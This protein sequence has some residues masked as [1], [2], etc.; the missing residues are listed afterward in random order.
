[1]K[2]SNPNEPSQG[3]EQ[4]Q[5]QGNEQTQAQENEQTQVHEVREYE[6][7]EEI[8]YVDFNEVNVHDLE[9]NDDGVQNE[10]IDVGDEKGDDEKECEKNDDQDQF[11]RKKR[12]R[13][14]KAYAD[15]TEVTAKD[16]SIKLQCIHCKAFL[17]KSASSTTTHLWNH[18][19]RCTQKKLHTKNQKTLQFQNAKSK[20]ETPLLSDGKYDHM[21]QREAIAHWILIHEQPLNVVENYGF[22]FMFKANLP[23]FEK[24]SRAMARND[25]ITVYEI[26]KKKL[27]SMLRTINKISLTTDIWK[28]KVQKISYMCVT[29]HFVDSNWQLQK[30]VLSFMPL[31]PPHTGVDIIYG[32][33]KSTKDWGIEHK[34]FTISVDNASNN[35]VAI[36]IAKQTFSRSHKL[37]LGGKLFHVRCTAY[38]LNLV[39]Q[40]DISTIK[41]IVEDVRNSV[42]F[43]NQSESRLLKFSEIV[44]HLGILVKKLILDCVT[45]WNSTYEMLVVAIKLKDAFPIFAQREPSYKCCPSLEDWTRIQDVLSILEAFY[46]AT[47][48]ISGTNY[49][50]SNVFLGVVWRVKHV[51]NENEF[52]H[53]EL[54]RNMIEKMKTKFDKYW[55][56]CNLLMSI[57]AILDPRYK[58]RLVNFSFNQIYNANDARINV[59]KVKD[60]LYDLFYEYVQID[61]MKI[62]KGSSSA[63]THIGSSSVT[64]AGST[65]KGKVV[66]SGLHLYDKYLDSVEDETPNKSELDIFLEEGVYRC[67]DGEVTSEFDALSWWKSHELK[68][69]ILSKLARDVLAIP[70]STVASEATFSA[71]TRVLDPYRAKLS[72]DMVQVL[73]CGADW[74]RQLHG[75]DKPIMTYEEEEPIDVILQA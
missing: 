46:E 27:Q 66:L 36:R 55:G 58:M 61:N 63:V 10:N 42:R 17:S 1:M 9:V 14:S 54:I 19:N 20:F 21:K 56:D 70:V 29:G 11:Q 2:S 33:M 69:S 71:G 22:T 24:L 65:S 23:Q 57:G 74:V 39:V 26:E 44:H 53:E 34:I 4:T 16:G 15:F 62:R 35:D 43:I 64:S 75:I 48:V 30:R 45:R 49:P 32:V 51:L 40:D 38:I 52:H 50:T 67:Q 72:S 5:A 3:N 28:S 47:H 18:L 13:V 12:K 60:A 68:F 7:D 6:V 73:I 25:V 8:N 31:P 59:T 41:T 37:P